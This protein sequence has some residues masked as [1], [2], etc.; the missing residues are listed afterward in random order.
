MFLGFYKFGFI[1]SGCAYNV[2]DTTAITLSM[3]K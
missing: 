3:Q 1:L 2:I